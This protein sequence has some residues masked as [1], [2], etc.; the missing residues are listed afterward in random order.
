MALFNTLLLLLAAL[1]IPGLIN[2]TRK[3]SPA[4]APK[5][6]PH[7]KP[8]ITPIIFPKKYILFP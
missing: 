2:R 1:A 7:L 4:M 3:M 5:K 8:K 6:P